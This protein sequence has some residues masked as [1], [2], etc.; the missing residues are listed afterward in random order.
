[1][2]QDRFGLDLHTGS[3]AARDAYV[4]G[5]DGVL[6]ALPGEV[7]TLIRAVA[8]DPAFA[9]AHIALARARFIRMQIPAAREAVALARALVDAAS[10]RE[11][12]HVHALA[13]A[14]EGKPV[15]SLAAT[16]EHLARWPRDAMVAAPVA[17][18]FGL[19]G[20]SGRAE[21]EAEL[22]EFMD[23]LAPHY[24][25]DWW[26]ALAHA[27]AACEM[28]QLDRAATLIAR[29]LAGEPRSGHG[30]HVHAHVLYEQQAHGAAS[31]YLE[32]WLPGYDRQA[33]MHCHLSW[34]LA[35]SALGQG[36]AARAWQ[37]FRTSVKPGGAWGPPLNLLTDA[38]S[39]LWRA[40]LAGQPRDE[41]LWRELRDY[42]THYFPKAGVTFADVHVALV[43]V[44]N[45][46]DAGVERLAAELKERHAAGRL[47]AGEVVPRI[48]EGLG[49]YGRGDWNRVIEE[50]EAA[51]PEA[52]RIG[53]SRAQRDL[54]SRT[55]FAAYLR[56]GRS[57][58]ARKLAR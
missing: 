24:G 22:L 45:G 58:E 33:V 2:L 32:A 40:E 44:A 6:G 17:G 52:Q 19:L 20:F 25:D 13:L 12:S 31:E 46:D 10:E 51:L 50:L 36:D 56:A 43:L 57:E 37:L 49:A 7:E 4:A 18:V 11:R 14:M 47:A 35:M 21:R 1:M 3:A 23:S 41:A 26:F 54:V 27:F 42:A 53:G 8:A 15:D 34:H 55:L 39:F 9:L 28:G 38:A 48:V 29:S 5:V 16:R 30:A